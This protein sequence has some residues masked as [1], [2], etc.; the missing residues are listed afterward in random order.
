MGQVQ[1]YD[2]AGSNT[3]VLWAAGLRKNGRA[4][5]GMLTFILYSAPKAKCRHDAAPSSVM[6]LESG[7]GQRHDLTRA[8]NAFCETTTSK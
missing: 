3:F 1:A 7:E 4:K 6:S 2:W 8:Q 5:L